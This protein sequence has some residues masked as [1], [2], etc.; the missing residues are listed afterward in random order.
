MT[1]PSPATG[2]QQPT[3][4]RERKKRRTRQG[5]IDTALEQF[6]QNGFDDVTLDTLCDLVEV[7]KRTFFR[8]FSSKEDV[9]MAPFRDFWERFL[10]ELDAIDV[11]GQPLVELLRDAVL[12]AL[13]DLGDAE[14]ARRVLLGYRL[15]EQNAAVS[16]HNLQFCSDT[17]EQALEILH[18][19]LTLGDADDPR[20][21]LAGDMTIAA[22]HYALA[23]WET[24]MRA[25]EDGSTVAAPDHERLS[26]RFR[27]A[28][29]AL[30]G[31][32]TV[33]A[34]IKSSAPA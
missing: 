4:L 5:L 29:A 13:R 10:Q 34:R 15:S 7:S 26:D 27:A 20:P 16:A 1:S 18:R 2:T 31:S 14:W 23:G 12:A 30:P 11:T 24:E 6:T 9:A 8:N 28:V 3:S 33:E 17:T 32:L 21:R 25:A 19:R 22:F